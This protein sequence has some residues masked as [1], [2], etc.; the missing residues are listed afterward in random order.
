MWETVEFQCPRLKA[1]NIKQHLGFTKEYIFFHSDF[2]LLNN[3]LQLALP[4]SIGTRSQ[5]SSKDH[6]RES[7]LSTL[8]LVSYANVPSDI[9]AEEYLNCSLV[10]IHNMLLLT[11]ASSISSIG[12]FLGW[13]LI[14]FSC[15]IIK[16]GKTKGRAVIMITTWDNHLIART[17]H[18]LCLY[19]S[20]QSRST[21][22]WLKAIGNDVFL[23]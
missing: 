6:D 14:N 19:M 15:S 3:C 9:L 22:P 2:Y 12:Y 4:V 20:Y 13:S 16:Q 23:F 7:C 1:L 5:S 17:F 21:F 8:R 10:H 11:F 18:S